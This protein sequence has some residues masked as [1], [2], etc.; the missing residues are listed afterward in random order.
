MWNKEEE[1]K[2]LNDLELSDPV[3]LSDSQID[4]ALVQSHALSRWVLL[5]LMFIDTTYKLSNTVI[6]V[7]L[8][9]FRVFLTVLGQFSIVASGIAQSLP[10]SLY[11][12]NK[13]GNELKFRN[14]VVCRKCHNIYYMAQCLEGHGSTQI[15]KHCSFQPLPL[16]PHHSMQSTCG[17]L[18]LKTV[19]L[20]GGRTYLYPFLLY[21]YVGLD[22]SLQLLLDG[23][24][25][26]NQCEQ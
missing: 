2:I 13:R 15:S 9:F 8:R 24:D 12:A 25:F 4:S 3:T 6:S 17:I 22:H 7:P 16:H 1:E 19:E 14:Y 23:P 18:L 11:M 26:F 5:F 10:S 20:A 21:C